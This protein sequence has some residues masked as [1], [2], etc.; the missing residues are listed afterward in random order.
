MG[1]QPNLAVNLDG[2]SLPDLLAR[3]RAAG[4]DTLWHH[5]R[6]TREEDPMVVQHK[7]VQ[8]SKGVN[9]KAK[10]DLDSMWTEPNGLKETR[11]AAASLYR[12]VGPYD[13][14]DTPLAIDHTYQFGRDG[15]IACVVTHP[16]QFDIARLEHLV[17]Y[18]EKHGLSGYIHY[19]AEF[20][21][22]AVCFGIVFI[23]KG[24]EAKYPT[25][26]AAIQRASA[27]PA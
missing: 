6:E 15:K 1:E 4:V 2:V 23:R 11:R 26:Q 16:Y 8:H 21:Y 10:K 7:A 24:E 5:Q 22:P 3:M 27:P 9:A 25:L 18:L 12:R 13:M 17:P 19:G 20:Y 14:R